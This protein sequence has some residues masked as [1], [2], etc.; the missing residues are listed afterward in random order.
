MEYSIF[1]FLLFAIL[2]F[3]LNVVQTTDAI[4]V[5]DVIKMRQV[6]HTMTNDCLRMYFDKLQLCKNRSF[7]L[8]GKTTCPIAQ[9]LGGVKRDFRKEA[10]VF[11]L[12]NRSR[13]GDR[14]TTAINAQLAVV[15]SGQ[16]SFLS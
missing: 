15:R 3:N 4:D 7:S 14:A 6:Q 11:G 13:P 9:W 2:S 8:P 12:L 1:I 10:R 16:Y 5:Q